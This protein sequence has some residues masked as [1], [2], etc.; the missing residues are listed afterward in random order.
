[1]GKLTA[2][3]TGYSYQQKRGIEN[4]NKA[5]YMHILANVHFYMLTG[6]ITYYK[7]CCIEVRL[8]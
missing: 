5:G 4:K 8:N 2:F 1:M 6:L 7:Q 3:A